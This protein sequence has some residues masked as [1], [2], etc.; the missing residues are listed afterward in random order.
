V[1]FFTA[2]RFYVSRIVVVGNTRIPTEM[3]RRVSGLEGY[4]SFWIHPQQ[5]A[6]HVAEALPP[7]ESVQ[8]SHSLSDNVIL[9]VREREEQIVWQRSGVRY[10][11]DENGSLCPIPGGLVSEGGQ[12]GVVESQSTEMSGSNSQ[13]VLLINDVRPSSDAADSEDVG[14]MS[15]DPDVLVAARQIAHLL[16]EVRVV[17]YV[18]DSGLQFE[19]ARGWQVYLGTG[20]DMAHKVDLLRAIEVQFAQAAVQ[21]TLVDLRY[22]EIPYYRLPGDNLSISEGP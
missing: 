15:I 13:W 8:V 21:P 2:D 20:D 7:L 16:P 12:P 11:V 17:E 6:T 9:H 22:P 19:H 3:I 18:P 14:R 10:W 1:W 4:S 5:M